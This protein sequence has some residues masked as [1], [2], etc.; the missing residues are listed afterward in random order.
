[1]VF[2]AVGQRNADNVFFAP[3]KVRKVRQ[4]EV[5][6]RLFFFGKEH[7]GIDDE[8]FAVGLEDRH[9]AP[10]FTETAKSDDPQGVGVDLRGCSEV[11]WQFNH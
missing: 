7:T 5:D 11:G 3:V 2:V 6:S 9:V 1:M 4:D 10:D 8:Q